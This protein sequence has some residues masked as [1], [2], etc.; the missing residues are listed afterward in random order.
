[1]TRSIVTNKNGLT[2]R[3]QEVLDY[4]QETQATK[5]YPPTVREL[6]E[7]M[8]L[9][10]PSSG[11]YYLNN[12]ESKGWI[13]RDPTKPRTIEIIQETKTAKPAVRMVPIIGDVAAGIPIF[14]EQNI[15]E[16]FPLPAAIYGGKEIY[17]LRVRGD[18]M[19]DIGIYNGDKVI[20]QAC[21]T[22]ENGDI[23]VA[24]VD[25]AATV[26]RFYK[27]NGHYRLQPENQTMDPIIVDHVNIQGIV[28]EV[29]HSLRR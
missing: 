9:K 27:E 1:M 13:R 2:Q 17:M 4:I 29:L 6:V 10:S 25:D 22:A 20:V 12:L 26:K 5:G 14:A 11:Q 8:G 3:E 24:L 19:I 28:L 21:N 23:V 7:N 18:S 16:Y 15:E